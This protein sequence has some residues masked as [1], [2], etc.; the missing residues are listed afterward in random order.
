MT[1][2]RRLTEVERRACGYPVRRA[3]LD[4]A[5][6]ARTVA[7]NLTAPMLLT[8]AFL[9][10]LPRGRGA[11][12]LFVSSG[13]AHRVIDGWG[14]YSATKRG[15]EMFIEV[16]DAQ[17]GVRAASVDPGVM[18][19]GMQASIRAADFGERD[20]YVRRY[21]RGEL[22]DPAAVARRIVEEHLGARVTDG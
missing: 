3:A 19:T 14:V 6:I 16:L 22:A 17:P 11:H 13:A 7:L 1:E 21:R 2:P 18:D 15:V 4:P 5:D 12:V 8:N 10:A 20:H 9:A